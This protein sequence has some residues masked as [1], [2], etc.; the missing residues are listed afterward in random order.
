MTLKIEERVYYEV[1]QSRNTALDGFLFS[2][3]GLMGGVQRRFTLLL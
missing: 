1:Q 2:E 3:R